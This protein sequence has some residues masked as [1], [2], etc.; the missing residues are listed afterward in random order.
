MK[1]T[2]R[3]KIA[4]NGAITKFSAFQT[5]WESNMDDAI[6][7]F[8]ETRK[9][10][11]TATGNPPTPGHIA[12]DMATTDGAAVVVTLMVTILDILDS[13]MIKKSYLAYIIILHFKIVV[14]LHHINHIPWAQDNNRCP[15]AIT[16]I[17]RIQ[18]P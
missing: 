7:S 6:S 17:K 13:M 10:N 18:V 15:T 1:A 4:S 16:R 2:L 9:I 14:Y 5:L 11:N 12:V 8:G 3:L